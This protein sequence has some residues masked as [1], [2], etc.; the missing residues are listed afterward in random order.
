VATGE[1]TATAVPAG[2]TV[3][4]EVVA[5]SPPE[6]PQPPSVKHADSI[7]AITTPRRPAPLTAWIDTIASC[8][9]NGRAPRDLLIRELQKNG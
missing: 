7:A 3:T 2:T 6:P 4:S 9:D 8:R 5:G 1:G